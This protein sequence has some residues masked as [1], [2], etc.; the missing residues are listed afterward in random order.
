[1]KM[2]CDAASTAKAY[3]LRSLSTE[4]GLSWR[5]QRWARFLVRFGQ[6]TLRKVRGRLKVGWKAA[7]GPVAGAT[8]RRLA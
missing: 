7:P 5:A 1:L 2:A 4:D 8:G 3:H 6:G